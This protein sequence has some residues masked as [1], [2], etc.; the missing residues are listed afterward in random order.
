MRSLRISSLLLLIVLCGCA[1][2]SATKPSSQTPLLRVLTYNIHAGKD[3]KQIDNLERVAAVIKEQD[4]DIV[5]LQE[6]DKNT[7]RSGKVDQLAK[8]EQLTGMHGAFG[9]TLDYQGGDYGIA[10]LS[11]WEITNSFM[12]P[13]KVE[14]PQ[15]R[16]GGSKEPRGALTVMT[17][18]PFGELTIINTHIDASREDTY[19][20]QE[21]P[22]VV[23]L[24]KSHE[25]K[26]A[27]VI[28]GG[29]FNSTPESEVQKLVRDSGLRDAWIECGTGEGL[30]Y[31]DDVPK[32]R[33]DYIFLTGKMSCTG[34]QVLESRAS[35]HRGVFF[36]IQVRGKK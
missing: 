12:T 24:A 23:A 11:K 33:I 22:Q 18:S 26:G 9:K 21:A 34:A 16:A 27:T 3:A 35:D 4:A 31:P 13:L 1:A 14:P 10:I 2:K 17:K 19:R 8:L 32:K 20:K 25:Q 28:V 7:Q 29:D 30:S 6:V 15:T 36:L 5:L